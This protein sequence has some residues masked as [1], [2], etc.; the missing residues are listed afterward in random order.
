MTLYPSAILAKRSFISTLW[1]C[2]LLWATA[3]ASATAS[4]AS[5]SDQLRQHLE[6]ASGSLKAGQVTLSSPTLLRRFYSMRG[7]Q[8]AWLDEIN[9]PTAA[10]QELLAAIRDAEHEGLRAAFYHYEQLQ[11]ALATAN[12]RSHSLTPRNLAEL[13]LLLSDAFMTYGSDLVSGRLNPHHLHSSWSLQARSIDLVAVLQQALITANVKHSLTALL[14]PHADYH[15]LKQALAHYRELEYLGGWPVIGSGPKLEKGMIDPRVK[16]LRARL[17]VSTDLSPQSNTTSFSN[18]QAGVDPEAIFDDTLH[19]AV[20]SFQQRHGL[21]EDG[22]V[23]R[24]TLAALNVPISERIRQIELNL[25]RWRW[26]PASLGKHHVLV[27]IPSFEMKVVEDGRSVF[28]SKVI[29]GRKDRPTP[30]FTE[31]MSHLVLS[32]YWNVPYSI[33]VKD[34]LPK[35]RKNPYALKRQRIRVFNASGREVNPGRVN[36]RAVGRGNFKYRLR[37]DPGPKNALGKVK[38]MFPNR[39][40]VYLHDT[41]SPELFKRSERAFSSGCIRVA[42][43]IELALHLLQDNPNWNQR[44]LLST[45][46][47]RRERTVQL[48]EEI[49]VHLLYWTAWQADD[50]RVHFRQDIYQRDK[51]L[52]QALN[53]RGSSRAVAKLTGAAIQQDG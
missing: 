27:N 3:M 40:S 26:L 10:T 47:K 37:Q 28:N 29:V 44:N 16:T 21:L 38:F 35:L 13:D 17:Q 15:K 41:S 22:I 2:A 30:I 36:W 51:P 18:Q 4:T 23:G 33:A 42:K 32:P 52:L 14:P 45:I 25:E 9:R 12:T 48:S 24:R 39:Y 11:Q 1:L 50:G 7:Y 8:P 5:V 46:G 53:I 34:K 20:L 6:Y 49:P 19:Q 31:T 43:P